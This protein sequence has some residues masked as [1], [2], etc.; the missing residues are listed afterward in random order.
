MSMLFNFQP[1]EDAIDIRILTDSFKQVGASFFNSE[2]SSSKPRSA[3]NDRYTQ[4]YT[5]NLLCQLKQ[6]GYIMMRK[7]Q[8]THREGYI[9]DI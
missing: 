7:G 9:A 8:R 3:T 6:V 1:L 4:H 2:E 5:T